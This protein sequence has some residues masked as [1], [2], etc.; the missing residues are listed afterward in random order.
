MIE[1]RSALDAVGQLP[2]GEIDIAEAALQFARVDA[3]KAD[4]LAA[5]AHLSDLA[6]A[7]ARLAADVPA[8]D[9]A[10]QATALC[11]LLA[12]RHGYAGDRDR[13]EDPDNANLI[14]VI[15]RR[16]G[17]P[18]ALGILWL[19]TARAAGW[20]A[21]GLDFPG[22]FLVGLEGG[23]GQLVL[24]VFD[25]GA[26]LAARELRALIKRVEGPQARL[27]PGVLAA[28]Q[29]RAV[30]LR[31]QNNIRLR[32]LAAADLAGALSCGE[33]MLRVAPDEAPLWHDAALLHARQ[34]HVAAAL[35]CLQRFLD[36]VPKGD[37]AS[38]ARATM[39]E[40]RARLN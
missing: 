28:M 20:T 15:E 9:V 21:H 5:R 17:L 29:T 19:H 33:D 10:T 35:R 37:A 31:L 7:A 16:R 34:D 3:P 36:L 30:L 8:G 18:V 4:W 38:Q 39:E 40:L 14:R 22:H 26:P 6:R 32:R 11:G 2:D 24:D 23:G 1:A 25:G 12:E 13:Y 27:R